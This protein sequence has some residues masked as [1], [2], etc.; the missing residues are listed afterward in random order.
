[1]LALCFTFTGCDE[2]EEFLTAEQID[3]IVIETTSSSGEAATCKFDM[4]ISETIEIE[5]GTE[6]G[7][8]TIEITGTVVVDNTNR[9]MQM[10]MTMS[11]G[12]PGWGEEEV[13]TEG[14][15]VGEWM[16]IKD[17][18]LE[19]GDQWTKTK[20]TPDMWDAQNQIAQQIEMLS[21]GEVDCKVIEV[22]DGVDCYKLDVTPDME[23]LAEYM[24]NQPGMDLFQDLEEMLSSSS[25]SY[26]QWV[27]VDSSLLMR[28]DCRMKMEVSP[29][30]IPGAT[31]EDF[32]KMTMDMVSEV[33]I[34][35]YNQPVAIELPQDALGATEI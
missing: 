16:Y 11:M 35:D 24:F 2:E 31:R 28:S 7:K 23:A 18:T 22:L 25:A 15:I 12:V 10:L 27:A 9:A 4:D 33:V 17:S 5:G 32:E 26:T 13:T 1:M 34:Y 14:Y 8:M 19:T 30:D 29:E 3:Q 20:L 21:S 6:S